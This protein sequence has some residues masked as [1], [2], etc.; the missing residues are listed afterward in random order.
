MNLP[1]NLHVH[2]IFV[3]RALNELREDPRILGL[4]AGGSLL[5]GK[6]DAFSDLDLIVVYE[7]SSRETIMDQRLLIAGKLGQLLSAFTGEHVGDSRVI[8]CLYGP[9]PLHVDLKFVTPAELVDRI[10]NPLILW[11]RDTAIQGILDRTQPASPFVDPQWVED[12]FWV[13]VHYAATKLGRGEIFELVDMIT[14]I[15]STVLGPFIHMRHGNIPRGVR[16]L[17]QEYP[18]EAAE[19]SESVPSYSTESC[20][21]AL[22]VSIRIYRRLRL[23]RPRL[24]AHA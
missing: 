9:Q 10:E 5:S 22:L 4:L 24:Y 14:F 16:K 20:Y 13:W 23:G 11:E 17:E 1:L 3:E 19:L 15:R 6:M 21:N 7:P 18:D 8:I 12:R 2:Q